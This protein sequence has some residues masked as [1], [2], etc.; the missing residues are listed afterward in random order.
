MKEAKNKNNKETIGTLLILI[1]AIFSGVAIIVNKFF[2]AS[3]DPLVFTALRALFIGII[4]LVISLL[5]SKWDSKGNFK[6][7]KSPW[8]ALLLIGIL[9][10]GIAFWM[11]FSGL[12]LTLGIRAAFL[13]KT[14][15]IYAA[16]FAFLF[17]K[18]KITK[19]QLIAMCVMFAG[20]ILMELSK[21]SFEMRIGDLLV[22]GAAVLWAVENTISKKAMLNKESNWVVTFSRMFFGSLLLIIIILAMGNIGALFSLTSQQWLYVA[23]SGGFLL[24]YVLTYYWGLKYINLS[25]AATILL[26]APVVSLFLGMVWLGEKALPLQLVGSGLILLGSYFVI[27]SNSEKRN[28]LANSIA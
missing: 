27:R 7:K 5:M 17:L 13:H 23:I 6:F 18:E 24:V 21:L 28:Q 26:L 10:G 12:N 11:F 2:V 8:W 19:K 25:K 22:L 1:T 16:I 9:G 3:I 20:L 15:P 14:L 4:F